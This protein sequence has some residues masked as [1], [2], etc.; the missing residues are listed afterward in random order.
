MSLLIIVVAI[1]VVIGFFVSWVSGKV[2]END[3]PPPHNPYATGEA[4]T[5]IVADDFDESPYG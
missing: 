5:G 1:L 3:Y 2:E 4:G